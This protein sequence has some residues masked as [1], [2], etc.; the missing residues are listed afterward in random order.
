MSDINTYA[1]EA[2][3]AGL[4]PINGD[5]VLNQA[6]SSLYLCTNA[7]ATGIARWK[8]F[9]NDSAEAPSFSSSALKFDG[10]D[11]AATVSGSSTGIGAMSLWFKPFDEI[12]TSSSQTL[13]MHTANSGYYSVRLNFNSS[14]LISFYTN[15]GGNAVHFNPTAYNNSIPTGQVAVPTSFAADTW[16]HFV[17]NHDSTAGYQIYLNGQNVTTTSK[18]SIAKTSSSYFGITRTPGYPYQNFFKGS[19]DDFAVWDSGLTSSE[20][21]SIFNGTPGTVESGK[22]N[23]I[24]GLSITQPDY[25]YLM[26]DASGDTANACVNTKATSADLTFANTQSFDLEVL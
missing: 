9:A 19:I 13:F 3:I 15:S 20:I 18:P 6:D 26:G 24:S 23:D 25:Y 16:Q 5:L 2:A 21:Q 11:D 8:K 17:L 10:I 12:T 7:D 22:P 4:S 1:D 14:S